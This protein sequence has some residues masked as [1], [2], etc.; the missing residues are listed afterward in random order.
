MNNHPL[1]QNQN[2]TISS[3]EHHTQNKSPLKIPRPNNGQA[4]QFIDNKSTDRGELQSNNVTLNQGQ[5]E[6][7]AASVE[8]SDQQNFKEIVT[9][10]VGRTAVT[11]I[12]TPIVDKGIVIERTTLMAASSVNVK[13]RT[14]NGS[15]PVGGLKKG[16]LF[17]IGS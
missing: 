13:D 3:T 6:R 14:K 5:T 17:L 9:N 11:T 2:N 10:P 12:A 8:S 1:F 4:Q 7:A 16:Q 15:E